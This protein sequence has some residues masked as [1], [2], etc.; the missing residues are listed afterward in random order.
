MNKTPTVD[1]LIAQFERMKA[2]GSLDAR[3]AAAAVQV[4]ESRRAEIPLV[5]ELRAAGVQVQSVW[6]LVNTRVPYP[7]A[8]PILLEHLERPYPGMLKEGIARALAV[9]EARHAW[10]ILRGFYKTE[11]DTG[12]RDGLALALSATADDTLVDE[13]V[14]LASDPTNGA[15]RM[16]F[17][18]FLGRSRDPK[19]ISALMTLSDDPELST[20]AKK[21]L[22]KKRRKQSRSGFSKH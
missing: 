1:E 9:P 18:L 6:D 16:F 20:E 17:L 22:A 15:S 19:S 4:A 14:E 12:A 5:A 3:R 2:D 8:I 13:V 21:Q 10:P 11:S 7:A